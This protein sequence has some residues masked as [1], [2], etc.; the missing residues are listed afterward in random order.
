MTN[1]E[2]ILSVF[3]SG[4]ILRAKEIIE[5]TEIES[6]TAQITLS[7]LVNDG[8]IEKVSY[9]NYRLP[10]KN[11]EKPLKILEGQRDLILLKDWV[12]S[13]GDGLVWQDLGEYDM[14]N[15]IRN[16][17]LKN[18]RPYAVTIKGDSMEPEFYADEAVVIEPMKDLPT[19]GVYI[20]RIEDMGH[21]KRI[22]RLPNRILRIISANPSYTPFEV[23]LKDESVDFEVFGRVRGKYK[24]Y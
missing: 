14:N 22:Q 10:R 3:K 8:R 11:I 4:E 7:R 24:K 17:N 21:I 2:K 19:D 9:G 1:P 12:F 15:E 6:A 23:N 13:A 20:F 16:L 18:G 5:R